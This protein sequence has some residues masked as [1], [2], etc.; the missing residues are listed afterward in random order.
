[1][2]VELLSH[3][4]LSSLTDLFFHARS[5][6]FDALGALS[7][8]EWTH[9]KTLSLT[10]PSLVDADTGLTHE[11]VIPG[12]F[13]KRLASDVPSLEELRISAPLPLNSAGGV[14]AVSSL[15]ALKRLLRLAITGK[16]AAS[17]DANSREV[18]QAALFH[19][20]ISCQD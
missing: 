15:K 20:Q 8:K 11:Q 12:A 16:A 19:V 18:L 17:L 9:L 5:D 7:L 1:M 4:L 13:L 3:R 6:L 10:C 2:L 14:V